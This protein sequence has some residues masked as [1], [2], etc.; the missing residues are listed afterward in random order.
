ML[1]QVLSDVNPGSHP[2]KLPDGSAAKLLVLGDEVPLSHD[3]NSKMWWPSAISLKVMSK[4][5]RRIMREGFVLPI[6]MSI[7]IALLSEIY[8]TTANPQSKERR[9]RLRYRSS[10][11]SDFGIA[12]GSVEVKNQDKLA[13]WMPDGELIKGQ[14]AND[15]YWIYFTTVR[16][17]ELVLDCAMF[18]FNM[19]MIIPSTQYLSP[20]EASML[21]FAPAFFRNRMLQKNSPA[22]HTERR[23]I[24]FLRNE[25]LHAA[26]RNSIEEYNS[27]D[28]KLIC[29]V[30]DTLAGR[31]CSSIE[32]DLLMKWVVQDSILLEQNIQRGEWKRYPKD[33]QL[34][35][36][37]DP[38]E[39]DD[40]DSKTADWAK[41]ARKWKR[42]QKTSKAK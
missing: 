15:H 4:L 20:Q 41:T 23:R 34:V 26:I 9:V 13:Y 37:A 2:C 38:E 39:F 10:P 31:T 5:Y 16:G 32:R 12:A 19:C 6:T 42:E 27:P 18:T 29:D 22:L 40:I 36:E 3:T 8:T 24:S 35:V 21:P 30:M 17:E 25:N 33:V 14:D 28:I 7:C 1:H 11:I